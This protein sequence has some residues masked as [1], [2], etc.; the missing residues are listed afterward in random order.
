[1][2]TFITNLATAVPRSI[3]IARSGGSAQRDVLEHLGQPVSVS[4]ITAAIEPKMAGRSERRTPDPGG[5]ATTAVRAPTIVR[6]P[7]GA[8]ARRPPTVSTSEANRALDDCVQV[9]VAEIE[10]EIAGGAALTARPGLS[11]SVHTREASATDKRVPESL[12]ERRTNS[13][14]SR[15][16]AR[17][18]WRASA[19][20]PLARIAPGVRD[21]LTK[22]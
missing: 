9:G 17:T 18:R 19:R 20:A 8:I 4:A 22:S 13:T 10:A 12:G 16:S 11:D 7:A 1:V 21:E 15:T 14:S 3:G 2:T 5:T 6:V